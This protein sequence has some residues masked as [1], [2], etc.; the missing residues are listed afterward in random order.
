MASSAVIILSANPNG[1]FVEG[2]LGVGV[3]PK[4]GTIL[5][6]QAATAQTMGRDTW[7]LFDATANGGVV[8]GPL[9]VLLED[10]LRGISVDTAYAAGDRARG[11]IPEPGDELNLRWADIAGTVDIAIGTTG[12]VQDATGLIVSTAGSPEQEVCMTRAAYEGDNGEQLVFCVWSA[13]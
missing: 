10:N 2:T 13:Y 1:K 7:E 4:P 8:G 11:Y 3:A 12:V 5:Q 6:I 9:I